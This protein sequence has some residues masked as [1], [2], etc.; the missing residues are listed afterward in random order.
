MMISQYIQDSKFKDFDKELVER[1][2][3]LAAKISFKAVKKKHG[4]LLFMVSR[5]RLKSNFEKIRNNRLDLMKDRFVFDSDVENMIVAHG[6]EDGAILID[7]KGHLINNNC[8]LP[9]DFKKRG[10]RER[11]SGGVRRATAI[12]VT[13]RFKGLALMIRSNGLVAIVF[14]GRIAGILKFTET[15]FG[16]IIPLVEKVGLDYFPDISSFGVQLK[17]KVKLLN[18]NRLIA[19]LN[20]PFTAK[21]DYYQE[22]CGMKMRPNGMDIS[23]VPITFGR[24]PL[25]PIVSE[26]RQYLP[27]A[28]VPHPQPP[29]N[30]AVPQPPVNTPHP[31]LP[32]RLA[33]MADAVPSKPEVRSPGES[34]GIEPPI[35]ITRRI[36]DL[37]MQYMTYN[38]MLLDN[39]RNAQRAGLREST[40]FRGIQPGGQFH[41]ADMNAL[42]RGI[43]SLITKSQERR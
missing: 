20:T 2:V 36:F 33:P 30:M 32:V 28:N 41:N 9:L 35:T 39:A 7:R 40:N 8:A 17:N 13:K 29:A 5:K 26:T 24:T 31:Q 1:L 6:V 3:W 34:R 42:L 23:M 4:S 18:I 15:P 19:S 16:G 38:N 14:R 10:S 12:N 43:H 25:P 11:P 22:G 27:P 21:L 37:L